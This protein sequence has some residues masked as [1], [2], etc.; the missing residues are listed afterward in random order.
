[1]ELQ[2]WANSEITFLLNF[3][4]RLWQI[5]CHVLPYLWQVCHLR[6]KILLILVLLS[7]SLWHLTA[8]RWVADLFQI[9]LPV[10][11]GIWNGIWYFPNQILPEEANLWQW[12]II[13]LC[14]VCLVQ[15]PSL[16]TS[17]LFDWRAFFWE[18]TRSY[19][20]YFL[21]KILL[22]TQKIDP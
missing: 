19:S 11:T 16:L 10:A 1:M 5:S 15:A 18:L 2:L 7:Y 14:G 13:C 6:D 20:T 9:L 3:F 17:N 4:F 12:R 8:I 22:I 21:S